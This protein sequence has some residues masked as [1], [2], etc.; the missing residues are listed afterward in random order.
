MARKKSKKAVAKAAAVS[1][2]AADKKR[3]V[4]TCTLGIGEVWGELAINPTTGWIYWVL[5][6]GETLSEYETEHEKITPPFGLISFISTGSLHLP[7]QPSTTTAVLQ[8]VASFVRRYADIPE[9]WVLP[10]AAYVVMTWVF[11][12]FGTVPY[13]RFLGEWGT[14]K[15][16]LLQICEALSFRGYKVGGN[17]TEAGLFRSVDLVR[18]TLLI[19]EADER[20]SDSSNG[21]TKL[22]NFGNMPGFPAIRNRER[23]GGGYDPEAFDVFGPKVLTT[24]GRFADDGLES[25]CITFETERREL[26]PDV[27]LD[28]RGTN[29]EAQAAGLRNRLLAFRFQNFERIKSDEAALRHLN[30][31]MAQI[32]APLVTVGGICDPKSQS[33]LIE[34]LNHYAEENQDPLLNAVRQALSELSTDAHLP[35]FTAHVNSILYAEGETQVHVKR[36]TGILRSLGYKVEKSNGIRMIR[37]SGRPDS[38]ARDA[39]PR[40]MPVESD[41]RPQLQISIKNKEKK[42]KKRSNRSRTHHSQVA[43]LASLINVEDIPAPD[44]GQR[45]HPIL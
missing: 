10:I 29:F 45:E 31:R 32:A 8:D 34:F 27:P 36:I 3:K 5:P 37:I 16:R 44:E 23:P 7:S 24:R 33:K 14:G 18:G 22:L 20:Y 15:T 40:V 28:L 21:M 1:V 17:L 19:D 30:P 35:E 11:E 38:A 43:S 25:R 2:K 9:E 6:N 39:N 42:T 4:E 13:L 26:R 12:K 41:A